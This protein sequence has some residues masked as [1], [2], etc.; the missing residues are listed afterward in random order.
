MAIV[1]WE[2]VLTGVLSSIAS[3]VIGG[4]IGFLKGKKKSAIAIERKNLLYQPLHDE[5]FQVSSKLDVLQTVRTPVLFEVVSN[6]YKYGLAKK[7]YKKCTDLYAL[8]EQLNKIN[9]VSIANTEIIEIFEKGYEELYGSKVDGVSHYLDRD[10]NEIEQSNLS[11]PIEMIH[12]TNFNK[13]ILQLLQNEGQYDYEVLV[14]ENNNLY[15]Y[16]YRELV[17]I[18]NS[19]LNVSINGEKHQLPPLK[20]ELGI[21]P[22]EY[23]ALN[24]DF[25]NGFHTKSQTLRKYEL[26]NEII[27]K[28]I[29]ITKDIKKIIRKIVRIYEI[30]E[31]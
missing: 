13:S 2:T 11:I 22:A 23:I 17:S 31:I 12:Q 29:V 5:L 14:D 4:V 7:L 6:G 8:I 9:L 26:R 10:G 21:K 18:F 15:E 30:E 24:Y 16:T 28:S 27:E 25:F 20:K 3:L 19:A 1:E